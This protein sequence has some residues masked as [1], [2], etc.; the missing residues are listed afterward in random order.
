MEY[1]KKA[2]ND[3]LGN[4]VFFNFG[5][6]VFVSKITLKLVISSHSK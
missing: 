1:Q 6:K 5:N 2:M 4:I 3:A